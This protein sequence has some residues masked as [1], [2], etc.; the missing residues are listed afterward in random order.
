MMELISGRP[1]RGPKDAEATGEK[2]PNTRPDSLEFLQLW[3]DV[4][5]TLKAL[6][7]LTPVIGV[8]GARLFAVWWHTDAY[9]DNLIGAFH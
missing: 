5:C 2:A 9:I 4:R 1:K 6:P 7:A 3:N 8:R